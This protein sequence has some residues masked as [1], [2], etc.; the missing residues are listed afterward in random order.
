MFAS[1]GI[2]FAL[3]R[4]NWLKWANNLLKSGRFKS[5]EHSWTLCHRLRKGR[6]N[7]PNGNRWN[8][9][10]SQSNN[11]RLFLVRGAKVLSCQKTFY[12]KN[13]PFYCSY[14][15]NNANMYFKVLSSEMCS[16]EVEKAFCYIAFVFKFEMKREMLSRPIIITTSAGLSLSIFVRS[17]RLQG[18]LTVTRARMKQLLV[19]PECHHLMFV[20]IESTEQ[21]SLFLRNAKLAWW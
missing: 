3:T 18:P 4:R 2:S 7:V 9:K 16:T 19:Q 15:A 21:L 14:F 17:I 8:K 5:A 1:T 11:S 20:V 6:R 12:H 13:V 10:W